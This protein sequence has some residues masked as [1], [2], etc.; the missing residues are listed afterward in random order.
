M[1]RRS[2]LARRLSWIATFFFGVVLSVFSVVNHA[3]VS[4]DLWPLP[5]GIDLPLFVVALGM[6]ALGIIVGA[7][8]FWV[9][10]VRWRLRAKRLERRLGDLQSATSLA[11]A[12]TGLVKPVVLTTATTV[13]ASTLSTP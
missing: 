10:M 3:P 8:L 2:S 9:Q 12:D 5:L 6:L 1:A 13:D 7:M 11:P 4:I